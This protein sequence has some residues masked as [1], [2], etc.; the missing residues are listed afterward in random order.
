MSPNPCARL[1]NKLAFTAEPIH[2]FFKSRPVLLLAAYWLIFSGFLPG[3]C[4]GAETLVLK[5]ILNSEPKGEFFVQR[6]ED[7]DFLV[8][9]DDL[10]TIGIQDPQGKAREIGG[11]VYLSLQSMAGIQFSFD[12]KTVSLEIQALPDLLARKTIDFI[13]PRNPKVHY[14]RDTS[15]FLNYRFDYAASNGMHFENLNVTT[16]LGARWKDFLFLSDSIYKKFP[17]DDDWVRL[18][19]QL[20]Y[21]RRENMERGIAGDF[22]ASSGDL[23]SSVNLGGLSY[24]RIYQIDPYFNRYPMLNVS[25]TLFLPS[26][27]EVYLD[28]TLIRKEKL[29]PGEMALK[30]ISYYGGY[31]VVDIVIRDAF[32]R[33]Q[34]L[35]APYYF[36]DVLLRQGLH[37][38]SYNVGFL[39]KDFGIKSDAY[40]DPAFSAFHRYAFS[41]FFNAG[42]RTEGTDTLLNLGPQTDWGLGRWGILNAGVSASAGKGN[43]EGI[44][45]QLRHS[46]QG[47]EVGTRLFMKTYTRHYTTITP[48]PPDEPPK[49]EFG[50]GIGYGTRMF[51][52]LSFDF[53]NLH[54][55]QGPDRRL[56]AV[57]YSRNITSSSTV[58]ISYR[59]I[60]EREYS[61]EFFV[62]FT[63]YPW[64]DISFSASGQTEKGKNEAGIQLQK[65]PPVGE[66][67]GFRVAMNRTELNPQKFNSLNPFFQY[68]GPYGIYTA[69]YRGEYG[70]RGQSDSYFLSAAG[71][72][73][74]VGHTLGFSRPI[75]DSFGLVKVGEIEGVMVSQNNQPIGRTNSSGKVFVP[76]LNA[77]ADNQITI[78]DRDIPI[79][80]SF[81]EVSRY[82]S[83]PLRSGTLLTFEATKIQAITGRLGVR[84]EGRVQPV[85]F[86]EIR[87]KV[88]EREIAFPTGRE[89]EFY[90]ENI[91][92]GRHGLVIPF[93]NQSC[94]FDIIIP[95]SDEIIIDLGGLIC[96][97]IH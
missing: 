53:A 2:L 81:P 86:Q 9:K 82:V 47:R 46:Y 37:E 36:T 20:I 17:R 11:E 97:K 5:V 59:S 74:Y 23:G 58:S 40:S 39:R 28:G 84:W 15:A 48:S 21:D 51:G 34:R 75:T 1:K 63:Y 70:D 72:L 6:T 87:L 80:Y 65:N 54:K 8:K 18:M 26:E 35:K 41:D 76:N 30:D 49:L 32:G 83:P 33:E 67:Y 25:E 3:A 50:A 69:E 96:E 91:Q 42:I 52:S 73:A 27:V 95:K 89:G 10:K 64:K 43:R 19:S 92:P 22:F 62:L 38:Y 16:E 93:M 66:G 4:T 61:N 79:D 13:P 24:S 71:G 77:Y 12:P 60:K 90:L 29:S 57:T 56:G 78:H 68:N 7:G 94:T 88:G 85:E 45:A 44:A 14:P 31:R 55:F